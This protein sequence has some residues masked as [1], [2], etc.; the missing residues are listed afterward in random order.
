M[1]LASSN[2]FFNIL[3]ARVECI[4]D[5]NQVGVIKL[6]TTLTMQVPMLHKSEK[7]V[8]NSVEVLLS[9]FVVIC[10]ETKLDVVVECL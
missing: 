8:A 2:R 3:S 1:L 10:L 4:F 6:G 9:D 5:P 7:D